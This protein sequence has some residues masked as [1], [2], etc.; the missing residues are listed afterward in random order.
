MFC[1]IDGKLNVNNFLLNIG[2]FSQGIR[3]EK[4]L[5]CICVVSFH[6]YFPNFIR[7]LFPFLSVCRSHDQRVVH[8]ML[9]CG[10]A[11]L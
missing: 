11:F 4:K 6:R 2:V 1:K 9:C 5:L 3:I 10:I 7:F 8:V